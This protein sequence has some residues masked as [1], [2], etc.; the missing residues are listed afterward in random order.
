MALISTSQKLSDFGSKAEQFLTANYPGQLDKAVRKIHIGSNLDTAAGLDAG[1][2]ITGATRNAT[3]DYM[4][5][6]DK[7]MGDNLIANAEAKARTVGFETRVTDSA[8][9]WI[10]EAIQRRVEKGETFDAA[11]KAVYDSIDLIGYKDKDGKMVAQ[12]VIKGVNDS[13]LVNMQVPFWNITYLNKIYKQPMLKGYAKHLV[14]EIGVPNVWAD[15]VSIWTESF[16]GMARVANVAK[17][18]GQHNVNEATKVR[19]HQIISQFVNIVADFEMST[20]DPIYGGLNG[21]PLTNAAIGD[22]EMYT[23]FM[24]EQMHNA[25]IYFGDNAAGFDGLAQMTA[26]IQWSGAPFEYIYNDN[27]NPTQGA[28]MIEMLN[29][30]IGDWLEE[31]NFMPTKVRICCSPTMYKCLKFALTSKVYNQV[32]PLKIISEGAFE[33]TDGKFLTTTP[34]KSIDGINRTYEFCSDPMLMATDSTNG[35]INPWNSY[36][37]DL[38]YITF[39]E[40]QSDLSGTGLTDVV[41]APTAISNMV[42]PYFYGASRDGLGRTMLKRVGS[43]IC[44]VDGAVKVI[45]G[46]G[47]NLSYS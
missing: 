42:L 11:K 4:E 33:G 19:T 13:D 30:M 7:V 1:Y 21:N 29:H 40:F 35:I 38:M 28:D 34:I 22:N 47:R 18:L 8:K 16:E 15:A 27:T 2:R 46:I 24:L 9:N 39:P 23:R 25:L 41:M 20:S 12:P 17:T 32:S 14:S 10:A 43:I 3:P 31:L 5:T 44:P 36:D 37:T 6:P 26:E 45:R